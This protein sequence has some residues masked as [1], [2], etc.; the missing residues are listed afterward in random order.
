[1]RHGGKQT[2]RRFAYKLAFKPLRKTFI[3]IGKELLK[4]TYIQDSG[5]CS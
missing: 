1:M 2:A 3:D 4:I 5:E